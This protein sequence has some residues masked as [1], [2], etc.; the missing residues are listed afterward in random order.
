MITDIPPSTHPPTPHALL[1]TP[2]MTSSYSDHGA[3]APAESAAP[4][5]TQYRH[6]ESNDALSNPTRLTGA[7]EAQVHYTQT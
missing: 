2:A 1:P 6:L 5:M 4:V 3:T 7:S